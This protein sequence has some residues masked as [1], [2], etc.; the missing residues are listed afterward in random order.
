ML[1]RI[2]FLPPYGKDVPEQLVL[3]VIAKKVDQSC[4]INEKAAVVG[5]R[6]SVEKCETPI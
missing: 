6:S 5:N 2:R 3:N 1:I 4:D